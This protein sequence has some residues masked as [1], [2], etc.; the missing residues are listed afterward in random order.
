VTRGSRW[1]KQTND[2]KLQS[3]RRSSGDSGIN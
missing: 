2:S 3:I 1:N